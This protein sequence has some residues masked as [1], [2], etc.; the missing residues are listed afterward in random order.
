MPTYNWDLHRAAFEEANS[1]GPW[2]IQE[3]LSSGQLDGAISILE[4]RSELVR[5]KFESFS[6]MPLHKWCLWVAL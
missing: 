6:E 1:Q 4:G 3:E 5:R 2:F